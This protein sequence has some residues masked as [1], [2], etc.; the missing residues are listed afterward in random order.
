M[1]K[2]L[3]PQ[4]YNE[5]LYVGHFFRKGLPVL[6]DLSDLSEDEAKQLVDFATGLVFARRGSLDRVDRRLFLLQP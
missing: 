5:V 1:V 6:M 2:K 3:R 4:N